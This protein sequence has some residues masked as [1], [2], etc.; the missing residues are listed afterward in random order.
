MKKHLPLLLAL[1]TVL[2]NACSTQEK[3][4]KVRVNP[5]YAQFVQAY[6]SGIIS[7]GSEIRIHLIQ[8]YEGDISPGDYH[9]ENLFK[10]VP[11]VKGKTKWINKHTVA[12]V[13]D[14]FMPSG[15]DYEVR[16]KLGSVMDVPIEYAN[17]SFNLAT[18]D[19]NFHTYIDGL[20]AKRNT[21]L[22]SQLLEGRVVTADISDSSSVY[23]MLDA[24]QGGKS[25]PISWHYTGS[26]QYRFVVGDIKRGKKAS[27]VKLYWKGAP[28]GVRRQSEESIEV[29]ALGDFKVTDI[30]VK[31][32]PEQY[33]DIRF[34]DPLKPTQNLDGLITIENTDDDLNFI[35]EGQSVRV[36]TPYRISGENTV[37]VNPGIRNINGYKM[38]N[39]ESIE[40]LFEGIKPNVRLTTN[41][42]IAPKSDEGLLFPFEAV[43]L[44][45]V[46][47]IVTKVHQNNI[48]QYL[49][50][51][52]L[53]EGQQMKRV[54]N[55]IARKRIDLN[56]DPLV[57][58]HE[59]NRFS[60]DLSEIINVDPGALY[61]ID[62]RFKKE[63][64]VYQC[65]GTSVQ[66][67]LTELALETDEPWNEDNWSQYDYW[68]DY[69]Y[70]DY[71]YDYR[72]DQRENPCDHS[73]Y[74]DK[75]V[76]SNFLASD[77]GMIAKAGT[78]KTIHVYVN[79]LKTTKPMS[80]TRVKF[81]SY[82]Q[83]LLGTAT[84]NTQGEASIH[85]EEKPFV[86]VAQNGK[87]RGY[88]KLR[89][90]E[91]LSL[92]KFDVSGATV[93]QEVKGYLYAE[94][95]V[96]RP[97]DSIY[98][99]FML[100]DENDAIPARHPVTFELHDP[101]GQ[102]VYRHSTT[103]NVHG[104]YDFR[105][106]TSEDAP[107]GNY[108]ANVSIG[109]RTFYKYLKIETVK[110]NRL[111]VYL[112]FGKETLSENDDDNAGQLSVKWLHGAVASNLKARI[113]MTVSSRTTRFKSFPNYI[114]DD[115]LKHF[116][117]DEQTIYDGLINSEGNA[118][119]Y[120]D[121]S[122]GNSA[123]GMLNAHFVTKVFEKG[124][125]FSID[126]YSIPYSPYRG[127]VG[128]SAPEGSL[129]YGTYETDKPIEIDVAT[130]N[131][132]GKPM[133]RKGLIVKVY[134][135]EW[136]WWWD[137]YS[138]DLASYISRPGTVPVYE[139]TLD[140]KQG[141]GRFKFQ[142]DRP[143]W[144]RFVIHV[145]DPNTQHS[146]GKVI[147]VD[148]PYWARSER[149]S[150]E[151]ATMLSFSTDKEKYTVGEMVKLSFPSASNGSALITLESGTEVVKSYQ[152]STTKG[153]THYSFRVT[154]DMAPNVY[155]HVTLLQ[156]HNATLNDLPIRMYGVAPILVEDPGS[157]LEPIIKMADVL[158]PES[159]AKITVKE[160]QGKEMTYTLAV[161]DDGLL[162][163]T[164]FVTPN[165]WNHFYAREALGV[166][167]WDVY[168]DVI[169]AHA[170]EMNKI[171]AVGGDG[172]GASKKPTK[173]NRFKPMVRYLGPFH[174]N[175]G[176]SK[177][178]TIDIPNYVG[179]VR[180]MVVAGQDSKYGSAEKTVPVRSPLMILGTLPRVIGP[181]EK[182]FL[183]VNVF[184]MEKGVKN[185]SVEIKVNDKFKINGSSRKQIAFV[186]PGDEV[187][188]FELE[189]SE[190]I[191]VGTVDILAKSGSHTARH[192]IEIDVRTPN[193]PVT[194][195]HES[196]IQ[197]GQSW[198]SEVVFNGI[199]GT[200]SATIELSSFPSINLDKRLKYLI[201]YPHGCIEQTTSSVFPQ[202]VLAKVMNLNNDYKISIDD[203]IREGLIRLRS[204][205]TSDGGFSY[206]P[207]GHDEDHWGTNYAG[208][209]LLEA[210]KIGYTLPEGLKSN[211]IRYQRNTAR[212]FNPQNSS[213]YY[214]GYENLSQA[215]RLYTLALADAPELGSMNRLREHPDLSTAV[216]WRLAAAYQLV[217]QTEVAQKLING[218]GY[219]FPEYQAT[220][221]T[222]GS[223]TRDLAMVLET[224]ILLK[225]K[226][227][228]AFVA[229][230]IADAMNSNRWMS[231]QTTAYS[232]LAM[233]KF[234]GNTTAGKP[235][236]FTYTVS[237]KSPVSKS[238][239]TPVFSTV[240]DGI[241]RNGSIKVRNSGEG[242]LYAKLVVEG[243]PVVG[244]Q[245]ATSSNLNMKIQYQDTEGNTINPA[246][247]VQGSDFV[248]HVTISNP[249][250]RGDLSEMALSQI[251]PSGW[252]IHNV[253]MD[254]YS[255]SSQSPF[256][257]QDIRDDRVYTY[258]SIPS[259]SSRT[260]V[261]KLNATYLGRFYLPTALCE[262]MYD[263]AVNARLPGRWVE[264][265]NDV[266]M[267]SNP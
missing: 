232:L 161:V 118:T 240:L 136:R 60:L 28:I 79:N 66:P 186:K 71:D 204:F 97:G 15:T 197:P 243:T 5:E 156:P 244:D 147:Y 22:T 43:N 17:F 72:Y 20:K 166:K 51:S 139:T 222:Y 100:E 249:G 3:P 96:W 35:V 213:S 107:T 94:R 90:G 239:G 105:T 119:F 248:A 137:S 77:I 41:G 44:R 73:Y 182:V 24:K 162:D 2:L 26:L 8:D 176:R 255:S 34:S 117:S 263:N 210:E 109:N 199:P 227:N 125:G 18:V 29:P 200:N 229:K 23:K 54:S 130:V 86:A 202:L 99:A 81:Y 266:E 217:G 65:Q 165:P 177:T 102:L 38:I 112:D 127:F 120:P 173:A 122:I 221:Y 129:E 40:L 183:P 82:T 39:S 247:I 11:E 32:E 134:K 246:R 92:S 49:Q 142:I 10:L 25:L 163:L 12:F 209:F 264:V 178:H 175:P 214:A 103:E 113:D 87:Q 61:Q 27:E 111:K 37:T 19:Q 223:N 195:V 261:V 108:S 218:V 203:N 191:G 95:G 257:Y 150:N 188:N 144:G 45:A 68:Y 171:L 170:I 184:A 138:N 148:W 256:D 259:N 228:A 211:W 140:T 128:I 75:S 196:V 56:K 231:T 58:L 153:E 151:N 146:C 85:L 201:R 185:V 157:H 110:P 106:A 76:K 216:R 187:V 219:D 88:L 155:V 262:A 225:D 158:R 164:S 234:L 198:N 230:K 258:F 46:D 55:E 237:G 21:D 42:T 123:P 13:P 169:G 98:V 267:A 194:D 208:H 30:K 70:W 265:V 126:R 14:E 78:D 121:I 212:R 236:K 253:R 135:V 154:K 83:E 36:Y 207:G 93:Q 1:L 149:T 251:F 52:S 189:V 143:E 48:L 252:E 84:T 31:H 215:Y 172:S 224:L 181:T 250:T 101:Q 69:S 53:N 205:Q 116:A 242:I 241:K 57:N 80:G 152:I 16:F 167:T 235:M 59:W 7:R 9:S 190:L 62:L 254:D 115:P 124:G 192:S 159:K 64:S 168:D 47:L 132:Q 104:L 180:V 260:Y 114:F 174:L 133:S 193:P 245:T 238:T 131:D 4:G 91:S 141:K 67:I 74:R 233:S 89:D 33:V 220:A 145:T 160:S 179:S 63:Y 226:P 206:W 6:T 50:V